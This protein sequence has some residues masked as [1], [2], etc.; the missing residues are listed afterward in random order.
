M[1]RQKRARANRSR[2]VR[3]WWIV[4]ILLIAVTAAIYIFIPNPFHEDPD[5][6]GIDKPIFVKGEL[7]S[8]SAQ[9]TG[10]SLQLPL[11]VLQQEVD[12]NIRY[13]QA[14]RSIIL[15]SSNNIM[16]LQ[17]GS[18]AA[19]LNMKPLQL[20][21]APEQQD[22]L[23]IP[24]APL[25]Q[26]Y[27]ID[28]HEDPDTGAV[29]LMRAGDRIQYATASAENSSRTLPL[30]SEASLHA[31]IYTDVPDGAHLRIWQTGEEWVQVQL[32]NGITGYMQRSQIRM[33]ELAT[34][35]VPNIPD[36][37][38]Q[39]EWKGKK[40]NLTWEAIYEKRRDPH[41]I[42]ELPGVNVISPTWFEIIDGSGNVRSKA[43]MEYVN[44]AHH[45]GIEVW[46]L[47]SNGFNADRTTEALSSYENRRHIITQMIEY[48][49]VYQLDG[50]N[51][52]FESVHTSDGPNVTQFIRELKPLA[53]RHSLVL[54]MDV[55]PK[56]NSELWSK[57]L[58]RESLAPSLDYMMV[59]A[60]D[61]HWAAS[62]IAGSVASLDWTEK[63]MR[64]VLEEDEVPADKLILGIP[65]YT[66]IWTEKSE[67]GATKVSSKAV[68][69]ESI[70]K[71]LTEK[72][73]KPRLD[74]ASGQNYVEYKEKGATY[75]I[76]IEDEVS[77]AARVE[78]ARK[79][80]LG[81][82][83]SWTRSLG[84]EHAWDILSTFK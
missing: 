4:W 78:L 83:A 61:E 67:N 39:T 13:E 31:P 28:V 15:T 47:L 62:P 34:I 58:D 65:L 22:V 30:R 70:A 43:D 23:Y 16:H 57:F 9:G 40:V 49:R 69:M 48:A 44:W 19:E 81:G 76:W 50:I 11:P 2:R 25:K 75:K 52:D 60:Y 1:S 54:S 45:R 59:M 38:V 74:Q 14:T 53:A 8:Y 35:P 27:H 3:R 17:Q 20:R 33:G 46:A 10:D 72:K 41:T 77:L 63:A 5:W 29:I 42:G 79:L 82:I 7:M 71:L 66:R 37:R 32:D 55:T 84:D 51:I 73:L 80:Q 6:K 24:L 26:I 18:T 12:P 36:N 56:S 68:G 21:V 64:R